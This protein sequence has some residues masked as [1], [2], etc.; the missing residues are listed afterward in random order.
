MMVGDT[1]HHDRGAQE[2]SVQGN[3]RLQGDR[4]DRQDF[5]SPV[6]RTDALSYNVADSDRHAPPATCVWNSAGTC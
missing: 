3:V 4:G 5:P 1:A 2:W 6:I